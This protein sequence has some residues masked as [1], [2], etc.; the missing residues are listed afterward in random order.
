[1][2]PLFYMGAALLI[3]GVIYEF[4][5]KPKTVKPDNAP[6]KDTGTKAP[7]AVSKKAKP[8]PEPEPEEKAPAEKAKDTADEPSEKGI[9][10]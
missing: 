2:V 5:K 3:G 10:D 4:T 1:M 6:S 8:K 7:A 9:P